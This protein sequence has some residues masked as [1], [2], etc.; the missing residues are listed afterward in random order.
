MVQDG[1]QDQN[2]SG[3]NNFINKDI[4]MSY[5]VLKAGDVV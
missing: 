5:I 1:Y 2:S 3:Y 4:I